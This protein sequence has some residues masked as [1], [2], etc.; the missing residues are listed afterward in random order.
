MSRRMS[1]RLRSDSSSRVMSEHFLKPCSAE[2]NDEDR[3]PGGEHRI[4]Q[5]L[6]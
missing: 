6:R 3:K 1:G 4:Q 5:S 2:R